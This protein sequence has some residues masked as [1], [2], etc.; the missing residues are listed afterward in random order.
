VLSV[1][2]LSRGSRASAAGSTLSRQGDVLVSH[3]QRSRLLSA[4][5]QVVCEYGYGEMSIARITCGAGVSRRTFYDLFE[6]REDCFLA[7][8]EDAASNAREALADGYAHG[9]GWR[10]QTRGALLA[11]LVLL[12]KEPAVASLLITDSLKAGPRVQQQ[13]AEIVQELSSALHDAGSKAKAKG[14]LPPL[15]GEG[16]VGAVIGVIH[17]RLL[18][19]RP[20]ALVDLLNPLMGMIVLPYLGAAAAHRELMRS[21]PSASPR[22]DRDRRGGPLAGLPMRI[23]YRTLL[24]LRVIAEHPGASNREIADEGGISDQGQ[25]S[26]LLTRLERLELVHNTS[27]GHPSGEPNRWQLTP[28]GQQMQ[29]AI[30][31]RPGATTRRQGNRGSR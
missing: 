23:T 13:R 14:K 17:T 1:G 31:A 21:P 7:M 12:D 16:V 19:Q 25:I 11:L 4:A 20:G 22:T 29:H 8:F 2:G 27:P 9:R 30:S 5:A 10:E 3:A 18:A 26:K 15:T 24:V 6:D 28:R